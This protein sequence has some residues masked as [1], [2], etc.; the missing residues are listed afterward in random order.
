MKWRFYVIIQTELSTHKSR[1]VG[2]GRGGMKSPKEMRHEH[3]SGEEAEVL[4]ILQNITL[5]WSFDKIQGIDQLPQLLMKSSVS[6]N[7]I[8][9]YIYIHTEMWCICKNVKGCYVI[10]VKC[11]LKKNKLFFLSPKPDLYWWWHIWAQLCPR[12][13][14]RR[15]F[16]LDQCQ[17]SFILEIP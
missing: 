14:G 10:A 17:K 3:I 8:D 5:P 7:L 6:S 1:G 11:P 4:I 9:V 2:S 16:K 12:V 15:S 13:C